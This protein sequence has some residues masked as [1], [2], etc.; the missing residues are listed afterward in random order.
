MSHI[1]EAA[2]I[3][4]DGQ[5]IPWRDATIH[6]LSTAVQFGTSVFEGIRC[7][8]TPRGPAIFRLGDHIRRLFDSARIYRMAVPYTKEEIEQACS[9]LVAKNELQECYIRPMVLRGYGSAGLSARNSP[10]E[11]FIACWPWGAYLGAGALEQGVDVRVSSWQR[12]EPN[13]FPALAK[14]AGHYNNSQLIKWE[15]EA[16]GYAE[17]IALG[18]GGTV[19]EG[20]GQNLFLVRDGVLITPPLDGTSLAGIT[21]DSI[22]KIARDLGIETREQIVQREALYTADE[23]F[24]T[25]TAAEVTPIR[26]VDRIRIGDGV[27]GPVTRT[28]Q[29]RFLNIVRGAA[30]DR[31]GW[32]THVR[33]V[34]ATA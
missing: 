31:H 27:A 8:K 20:S 32:L 26:S 28:L 10:I 16:D 12:P 23:L 3:W 21:R 24:F 30:D 1:T 34:E 7:Y 6:V 14:A 4:R 29:E 2:W 9:D 25:G 22:L 19:S 18:P 5:L 11:V 33:Q 17:G 13:T 15:A